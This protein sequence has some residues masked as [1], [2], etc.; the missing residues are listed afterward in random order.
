MLE[1]RPLLLATSSTWVTKI[2]PN[3]PRGATVAPLSATEHAACFT[4]GSR[5]ISATK[6]EPHV[7]VVVGCTSRSGGLVLARKRVYEDAV[8]RAA[9]T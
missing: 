5:E 4:S 9:V 8:Q 2:V 6:R 1:N 7:T 3:P